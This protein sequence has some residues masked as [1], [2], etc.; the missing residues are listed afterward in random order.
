MRSALATLLLAL[1]PAMA[2][3][4][5]LDLRDC[6]TWS[7]V[8]PPQAIASERYAAEEFRR[9]FREAT[10]L[11]LEI[12]GEPVQDTGNVFIGHSPAMES[13]TVGFAV[14][15]LGD[16]GLRLCIAP[17]NLAIA[18]GRPRGTLY[19][20][21]EFAERHLGVRFLTHDHTYYPTRRPRR[22]PCETWTY[23]PPFSFRW[24]Y[25]KENA[26]RPEFAARLRN[27]TVTHDD[28]LGGVTPQDL[29]SHTL[30]QF[31]PVSEY[32]REHPEYFALVDG[33]RRLDIG[34]GGPEPCVTHPEVIE[35]VARRVIEALD[36]HPGRRNI[37]VSQNDNDAYCRCDRCEELNQREGTPMGSHL[38]FVN[39]VAERVELKHPNVKIGT[40]AYWYTRKAPK[41]IRPRHNVQIQLCSIEC[42]TLFALDDPACSKNRAFCEDMDA[43]SAIC[44]DL[45]IWNYNTNF[46]F[47]DLPFPNLRVIS[48][49]LQYFLRNN[50]HGVFMQANGNGNTG[51]LCDL[52]NYVLSRCLWNPD[53]DGW[54]L[55]QEFCRLHY[56]LAGSTMIRYLDYLHDHALKAGFEPTCFP[57]PYEVG[58][59]PDSADSIFRLFQLALRKAENETVRSRVE[60][61][62][63][64]ADRALLEVAGT[65]QE[66]DG[67]LRVTWPE[68]YGDL[69]SRYRELTQRHG[70]TRAEE[71]EPIEHYYNLLDKA[72]VDGF[73]GASLENDVWRL[74]FL[75][76]GEGKVIELF[77]K[78]SRK[79]LLMPPGYRSL[80]HLF[81]HLTFR[82]ATTLGLPADR[83]GAS[84]F[85]AQSGHLQITTSL[86]DGSTIQRVIS[87]DTE[88]PR[89]IRFS[90]HL[91]SKSQEPQ[92][93]QFQLHS[94]F[95]TGLLR[96]DRL[97]LL[98]TRL[99][100]GFAYFNHQDRFGVQ[101]SYSP[102]TFGAP[103]HSLD[104]YY[105]ML[106]LDATTPV[107]EVAPGTS[108]SFSYD[109]TFLDRP[110]E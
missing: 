11:D 49:N 81:E 96:G 56:G 32:G 9:L 42:S 44:K 106:R 100:H 30:H 62:S 64:A 12:R 63:I 94:E 75:A 48:P 46:R 34:G 93:F 61:A 29:I 24:S 72:T 69:T 14:E 13:S 3:A 47:Y 86:D 87:F 90:T 103:R 82:Q 89:I 70:Q 17:D 22:I 78:P 57:M 41:T 97:R 1:S 85:Q 67:R 80:R 68:A 28:R 101:L 54:E 16:E 37:S 88:D 73:R 38:A 76:E 45:W 107:L 95:F 58:I 23:V 53:L 104:D 31:L 21:Y 55:A 84:D 83:T 109:L 36:Q 4:P 65:L 40:L 66:R 19:G 60:K 79:H 110:P 5:Q 59:D 91:S 99:D 102:S 15:D 35:I 2:A 71:W 74:L 105:P 43:W 25:Y 10:S 33:Q 6:R 52:R 7:I 18:G 98:G 8:V 51:E 92:S 77:H 39:A 27:N 108:R 50:V 26:D 20:V